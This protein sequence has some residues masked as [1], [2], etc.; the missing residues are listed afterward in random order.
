MRFAEVAA[1][2]VAVG[3]TTRRSAKVAAIAELLVRLDPDEVPITVG[4][5]T[6]D[7]RQGRIGIGWSTVSAVG[8]TAPAAEPTLTIGEVDTT[9][10]Q[11]AATTGA[12]S[13]ERRRTL[14]RDLLAR[15]TA[16]DRRLTVLRALPRPPRWELEDWQ[17]EVTT[18]C[19]DLDASSVLPSPL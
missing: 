8:D 19:V 3:A 17:E 14:L 16:P 6:G 5:L 11:V 2:S 18:R 12:T 10:S 9:L 15:A 4:M 7:L 13:Q 1:T